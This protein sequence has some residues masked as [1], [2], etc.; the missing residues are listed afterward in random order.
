[1][2]IIRKVRYYND[3]NIEKL[4]ELF[5]EFRKRRNIKY[6]IYSSLDFNALINNKENK[7]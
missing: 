3:I 1:M 6:Y 7:L 5:E 4:N 2:K